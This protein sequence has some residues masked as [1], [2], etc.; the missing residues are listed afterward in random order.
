MYALLPFVIN[1]DPS[2]N[3]GPY[4]LRFEDNKYMPFEHILI[5]VK[6]SMFV[7]GLSLHNSFLLHFKF[8]SAN[9]ELFVRLCLLRIVFPYSSK[10]SFKNFAVR[11]E[12]VVKSQT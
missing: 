5:R 6:F 3:Y 2:V 12:K 9:F 10:F 8:L 7:P 11:Y 4:L 1:Q